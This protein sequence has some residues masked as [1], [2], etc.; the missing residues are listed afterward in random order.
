MALVWTTHASAIVAAGAAAAASAG[1]RTHDDDGS[2]LFV[3][4]GMLECDAL[5]EIACVSWIRRGLSQSASLWASS[6]KV[7]S[8]GFAILISL[9]VLGEKFATKQRQ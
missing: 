7:S 9:R 6:K 3:S 1:A 4:V 5:L 2:L 8:E